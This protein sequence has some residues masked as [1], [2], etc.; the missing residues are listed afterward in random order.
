MD[1]REECMRLEAVLV[2]GDERA[3]IPLGC[4]LQ[5]ASEWELAIAHLEPGIGAARLAGNARLEVEGL[6]ALGVCQ[7]LLGRGEAAAVTFQSA[8]DRASAAFSRSDPWVARARWELGAMTRD[9]AQLSRAAE[10]WVACAQPAWGLRVGAFL[11]QLRGQ[12]AS[13]MYRQAIAALDHAI[14]ETNPALIEI[15]VEAAPSFEPA[16]ARAALERAVRLAQVTTG[17]SSQRTLDAIWALVHLTKDAGVLAALRETVRGDAR[18]EA[19]MV[20]MRALIDA[21]TAV[22]FVEATHLAM[23]A[24]VSGVLPPDASTLVAGRA[25]TAASTATLPADASTLVAISSAAITVDLRDQL[26]AS[27]LQ[28]VLAQPALH[29]LRV[30]AAYVEGEYPEQAS[31]IHAILAELAAQPLALRGLAIVQQPSTLAGLPI[32]SGC[33]H[34]EP[35]AWAQLPRLERLHLGGID[36]V[37]SIAHPTLLQL[38]LDDRP[39]CTDGDWDLP[40]LQAL[41]WTLPLDCELDRI[42]PLWTQPLPALRELAI[43][44]SFFD[45]DD[46]LD[47]ARDRIRGL[48]RLTIPMS[49]LGDDPYARLLE[50]VAIFAHLAVLRITDADLADPRIGRLRRELPNLVL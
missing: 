10:L 28:P 5:L 27:A 3:R 13:L 2:A 33:D 15:L 11:A 34:A 46:A 42:D 6:V 12:P 21:E 8:I 40:A 37:H 50:N 49:L 45:G 32:S 23:P 24:A 14:G 25:L 39:I 44:A 19:A 47:R 38:A 7:R 35:A 31:N 43:H 26:D 16:E 36:L 30:I 4:A 41:A 48:E 1:L 17:P 20:Y 9:E 22:A 29:E 18:A